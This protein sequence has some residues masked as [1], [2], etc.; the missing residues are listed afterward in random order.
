MLV[1]MPDSTKGCKSHP[2]CPP[3]Q[4]CVERTV[5]CIGRSCR[6][7]AKC[8]PQG[9]C[10]ALECPPSHVCEMKPGPTCIKKNMSQ[11]DI[12]KMNEH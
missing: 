7:V 12:A 10:E 3:G 9:T 6:K 8:A 5:P 4:I 2:P 1:C 11:A